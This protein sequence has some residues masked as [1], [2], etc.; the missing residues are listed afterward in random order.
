MNTSKCASPRLAGAWIS[1]RPAFDSEAGA[2]DQSRVAGSGCSGPSGSAVLLTFPQ[3]ELLSPQLVPL[4]WGL[5]GE[6]GGH[7][8]CYGCVSH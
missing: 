6:R 5:N 3:R 7:R 2:A 8:H 1:N 4:L